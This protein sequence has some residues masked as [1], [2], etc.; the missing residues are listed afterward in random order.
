MFLSLKCLLFVL[1]PSIISIVVL[2]MD[3]FDDRWNLQGA[4]FDT[5]L[6]CEDPNSEWFVGEF[7]GVY[8]ECI[9]EF[10]HECT[11]K[12]NDTNALRETNQLNKLL[13]FN[14]QIKSNVSRST[15][16]SGACGGSG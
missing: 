2:V 11:N 4:A 6:M 9:Q 14:K 5:D 3:G 12:N 8:R 7:N 1:R 10:F 15:K 13:F 16:L